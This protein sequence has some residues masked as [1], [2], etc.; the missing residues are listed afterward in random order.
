M[1][2]TTYNFTWHMIFLQ[3]FIKFEQGIS[4]KSDGQNYAESGIII[5]IIIIIITRF[6]CVWMQTQKSPNDPDITIQG[7]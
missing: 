6:D 2:G 7:F 1:I 5:I 4:E 3:G